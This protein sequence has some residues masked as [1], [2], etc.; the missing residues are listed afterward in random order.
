VIE[1]RHGDPQAF[2][3]FHVRRLEAL[4]RAGH[5][6]RIDAD[7]WKIPDDI[8]ERGLAYDA[9]GR[10]KAEADDTPLHNKSVCVKLSG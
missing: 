1:A 3:R 10:P 5:V 7:H 8:A 2:I 4:R 9:P 6:E